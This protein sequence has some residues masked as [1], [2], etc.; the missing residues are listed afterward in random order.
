MVTNFNVSGEKIGELKARCEKV[1]A[2]F[3]MLKE[4]LLKKVK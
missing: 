3:K 2:E 4:K 1:T